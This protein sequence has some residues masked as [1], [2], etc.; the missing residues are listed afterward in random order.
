[1][2]H[3]QNGDV[4][5]PTI[6]SAQIRYILSRTMGDSINKEVLKYKQDYTIK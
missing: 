3:F 1:M 2:K 4:S 5:S 6:G